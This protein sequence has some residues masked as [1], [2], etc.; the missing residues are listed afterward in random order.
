MLFSVH[1]TIFKPMI[2]KPNNSEGKTR[3]ENFTLI[4]LLVV[5][6]IIAIL[7]GMLLPAL[8]QARERAKIINCVA[9]QKQI[10]TGTIMYVGDNNDI[11]MPTIKTATGGTELRSVSEWGPKINVGLGLA[12]ASGAFGNG[13]SPEG[14]VKKWSEGDS[15]PK[16]FFCPDSAVAASCSKI[17]DNFTDYIYCRDSSDNDISGTKSFNKPFTRLK[18]EVLTFCISGGS[19]LHY[20]V[21]PGTIAAHSNSITVSRA[22]GSAQRVELSVYRSETGR[23]ERLEAIDKAN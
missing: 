17:S 3:K 18:K 15:R 4:E 22:D 11:L 13:L 1:R 19:W 14:L 16:V 21:D 10:V 9:N 2:V 5:I 12:A 7:A 6:V 23:N 8:N 20:G